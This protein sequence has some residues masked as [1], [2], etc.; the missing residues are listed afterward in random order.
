MPSL[1]VG[2]DQF[3]LK[4]DRSIPPL[5]TV[6]SGAVIEIDAMD[7]SGGQLTER[8]VTADLAG[9][10]FERVDQAHGPVFVESAEPGDALEIE[11]LDFRP[12]SWGWTAI[13]PGFGLLAAD[14]PEPALRITRIG[15]DVAEFLPGVRVPVVPFC[16]VL[17]VA[18]ADEGALSTIPPGPFGGNMDTR[19]LTAGSKLFLPVF[20]PGALFSLGDGHAAQGD[21]EVCGTAIETSMRAVVRLTVR[22]D[23]HLTA[24]EFQTPESMGGPARTGGSYATDGVGPDLMGAAQD[25]VRH[26][27]DYLGRAHGISPVD[28][29]M[30]CSVAVDLRISEIVD[31]PNW[32]VTAHC[33]LSIFD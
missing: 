15:S 28:A 23:V 14:F 30:L 21:G 19:H 18:P 8:S 29:Y 25:A 33:P 16:G 10:D 24:P 11:L 6:A 32:I 5:A 9:L 4:W 31:A 17:G 26:M 22:K 1:H 12:G 7:A 2:S 27:I 3:H 20:A 13:A